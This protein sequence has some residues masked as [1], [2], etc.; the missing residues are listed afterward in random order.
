MYSA[1]FVLTKQKNIFFGITLF[2]EIQLLVIPFTYKHTF[3]ATLT[4]F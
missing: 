3:V 2:F 4:L 1:S